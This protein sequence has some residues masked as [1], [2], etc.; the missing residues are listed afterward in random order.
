MVVAFKLLQCENFHRWDINEKAVL[1]KEIRI[2]CS[3][4][5]LEVSQLQSQSICSKS[6]SLVSKLACVHC[7]IQNFSQTWQVW[8]SRYSISIR[9]PLEGNKTQLYG[10]IHSWWCTYHVV[11]QI[12]WLVYLQEHILWTFKYVFTSVARRLMKQHD[13]GNDEVLGTRHLLQ[14]WSAFRS[15]LCS[16]RALGGG[17]YNNNMLEGCCSLDV[18]L[19]FTKTYWSI[20]RWSLSPRKIC[21]TF[22]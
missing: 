21:G 22:Q 2:Q 13:L 16:G 15:T 1:W 12:K 4:I 7:I 3:N 8:L 18:N 5:V 6:A 10:N 20:A 14:E 17:C 19:V 9:F 11:L